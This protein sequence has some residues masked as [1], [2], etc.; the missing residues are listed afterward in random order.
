M[1][2]CPTIA[3]GGGGWALLALTDA[4]ARR[5][6]YRMI[7]NTSFLVGILFKN[8]AKPGDF[9]NTKMLNL[10]TTGSCADRRRGTKCKSESNLQFCEERSYELVNLTLTSNTSS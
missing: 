2:K 9:K 1:G 4:L 10:Y 6:E 3:R 8:F 7:T 5:E